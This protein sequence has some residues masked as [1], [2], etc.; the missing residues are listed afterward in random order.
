MSDENPAT[1]P[2]A[3]PDYAAQ[4]AQMQESIGKL[5]AKNQE[6][7]S[8]KKGAAQKAKE[9]EAAQAKALEDAARK[10]GDVEALDKSWGEKFAA[11]ESDLMAQLQERDSTIGGLTSG[12]QAMQMAA[13]LAVDETCVGILSDQVKKRLTTEYIDGSPT[14]VVLDRDGKRSAQTV[15]ELKAELTNEPSLSRLVRGSEA[16]GGGAAGSKLGG[17]AATTGKKSLS[18]VVEGF[19]ALPL[20]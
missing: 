13:E 17:S 14:T 3:T 16:S 10:S 18:G 8:E 2:E 4:I 12:A 19:D 7:L 9:A 1:E 5:Q 20:R 15:A 11:R 6:L